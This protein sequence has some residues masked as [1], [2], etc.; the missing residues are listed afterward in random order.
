M[1]YKEF[2]LKN[3]QCIEEFLEQSKG[4]DCDIS[5]SVKATIAQFLMNFRLEINLRAKRLDQNWLKPSEIIDA[6][7]CELR[8][9]IIDL[10][11]YKE[12]LTKGVTHQ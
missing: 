10:E 1:D 4:K 9:C 8:R 11:G 6:Q 5:G 2:D 3:H 7:V 12:R